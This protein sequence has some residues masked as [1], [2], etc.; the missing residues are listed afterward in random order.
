MVEEYFARSL[1]VVVVELTFWINK[2][3]Q[4]RLANLWTVRARY[5]GWWRWVEIVTA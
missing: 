2:E 5:E 1:V 3:I 4:G